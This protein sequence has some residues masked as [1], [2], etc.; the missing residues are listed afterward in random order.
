MPAPSRSADSKGQYAVRGAGLIS[1]A[2]LVEARKAKSDAYLVT[3][4]WVD[5]YVTG[6]NQY[7]PDTYDE[8]SFESTELI[9]AILDEHC[10]KHP[11]D[12][13]FGVINS[14]F[15]QVRDD[16]LKAKSEKVNVTAGPRSARHYVEVIRR[17]QAK[18]HGRG[19]YNGP[20]NGEF[21]PQ[22]VAA[23]KKFQ[24]SIDFEPTGFPDQTTLW[25]LLRT[26]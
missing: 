13:V 18:L 3:A 14:L 15:K 2:L 1:C 9:M 11:A 19:F 16:R 5:G 7:A 6:I 20:V 25:R 17:V 23:I 24:K 26:E 21:T 12:P 8:L 4:A 22:T 10:K